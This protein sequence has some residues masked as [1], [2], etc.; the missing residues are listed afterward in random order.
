[1]NRIILRL[2]DLTAITAACR[3]ALIVWRPI[4]GRRRC[5]ALA[6]WRYAWYQTLSDRAGARERQAR[7][8]RLRWSARSA[9]AARKVYGETP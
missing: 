8:A 1:M 6:A 4:N 2:V 7:S 9:E 5:P 3:Y